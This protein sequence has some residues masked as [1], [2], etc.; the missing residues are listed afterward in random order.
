MCACVCVYVCVCVC[1]GGARG[2]VRVRGHARHQRGAYI[3]GRSVLTLRR[4]GIYSSADMHLDVF[5][6]REKAITVYVRDV[7]VCV[8]MSVINGAPISPVGVRARSVYTP[9]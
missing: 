9:T 7:Y 8:V 1:A 3:S 4:T 5:I 2:C 6:S